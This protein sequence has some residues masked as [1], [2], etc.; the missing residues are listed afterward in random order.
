M[1]RK[2]TEYMAS[3]VLASLLFSVALQLGESHDEPLPQHL[4]HNS[5]KPFN[6]SSIPLSTTTKRLQLSS[7]LR[8]LKQP[9]VR[10]RPSD[11]RVAGAIGI[12]AKLIRQQRLILHSPAWRRP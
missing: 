2:N 6:T 10:L 8:A 9:S 1:A 4:T 5:L 3:L 12:A 11:Y 7:T